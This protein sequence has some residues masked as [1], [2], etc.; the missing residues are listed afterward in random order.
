VQVVAQPRARPARRRTGGHGGRAAADDG[1][2][3][4]QG[5]AASV[6]RTRR[7]VQSGPVR[8]PALWRGRVDGLGP[9]AGRRVRPRH[10][11][12]P[13]RREPRC[14][15][16]HALLLLSWT[17]S[18][19][20]RKNQRTKTELPLCLMVSAAAESDPHIFAQTWWCT[21]SHRCADI[22]IGRRSEQ[23]LSRRQKVNNTTPILILLLIF[24]S[25]RRT[26]LLCKLLSC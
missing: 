6:V 11:R 26:I 23:E 13:R 4:R 5:A 19:F 25:L 9:R 10:G 20:L 12:R 24:D 2:R 8:G 1:A 15:P 17:L 7:S 16:A 21:S 22:P 3:G 14:V 18:L